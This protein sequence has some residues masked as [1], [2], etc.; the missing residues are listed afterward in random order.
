M[1]KGFLVGGHKPPNSAVHWIA[2][3]LSQYLLCSIH[4]DHMDL[5]ELLTGLLHCLCY[6]W[7][8]K[9]SFHTVSL[10]A[11]QTLLPPSLRKACLKYHSQSTSCSFCKQI[12]TCW[13]RYFILGKVDKRIWE[14]K[15]DILT[16]IPLHI[17]KHTQIKIY[18][19]LFET[20][21]GVEFYFKVRVTK[22]ESVICLICSWFQIVLCDPWFFWRYMPALFY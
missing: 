22:E 13:S 20:V 17:C 6:S 19:R 2:R 10:C 18:C 5:T 14:N 9:L 21:F 15:F 16:I 3:M 11:R 1:R 4:W 7:F 8:A 12:K